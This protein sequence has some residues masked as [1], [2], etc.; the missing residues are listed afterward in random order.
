MKNNQEDNFSFLH[1]F[2]CRRL[3]ISTLDRVQAEPMPQPKPKAIDAAR[4]VG[5]P[6]SETKQVYLPNNTKAHAAPTANP[7]AEYKQKRRPYSNHA[8]LQ[9]GSIRLDSFDTAFSATFSVSDNGYDNAYHFS[10]FNI[11]RIGKELWVMCKVS[12]QLSIP[13]ICGISVI[14]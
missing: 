13:S 6:A 1:F 3:C 4:W 8:C 10:L 9:N 7:V 12:D 14:R 2:A 11:L 5:F